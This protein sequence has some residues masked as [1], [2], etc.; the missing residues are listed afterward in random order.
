[1]SSRYRIFFAISVILLA[2]L[3]C[4]LEV[5]SKATPTIPV[6]PTLAA[7]DTPLADTVTPAAPTADSATDTPTAIAITDT[8][9]LDVGVLPT[10]TTTPTLE[11]VFAQVIT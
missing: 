6:E 8:A 2:A 1:M 5:R 7:S 11:P 4:G 10:D 3:A 9:T